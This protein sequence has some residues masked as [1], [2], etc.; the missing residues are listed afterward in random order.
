MP[1][2]DLLIAGATSNWLPNFEFPVEWRGGVLYSRDASH[3]VIGL[4]STSCTTSGRAK[5]NISSL[6]WAKRFCSAMDEGH[7]S[8]KLPE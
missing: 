2:T 3:L 5:F 8:Q 6:A 1:I 7:F 4:L